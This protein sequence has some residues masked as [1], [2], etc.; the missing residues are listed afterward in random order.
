MAAIREERRVNYQNRL[1]SISANTQELDITPIQ[2]K[3]DDL[4]KE[5][6]ITT[7]DKG[8][9]DFS[10]SKL[11][12]A[13]HGKIENIVND[14]RDWGSKPG[15]TTP[16]MLDTLKQR[17]DDFYSPSRNSS[18]FVQRLKTTIK[19]TIVKD[20]P[21]Y[22]D[23]TKEYSRLSDDIKSLETALSLK[24][25]NSVN[26]AL[27][28]LSN[29]MKQDNQYRLQ[30]IGKLQEYAGRDVLSELAGLQFNPLFPRSG[31]Y[32]RVITGMGF[33]AGGAALGINPAFASLL[34]LGSPR[35]VGE[36]LNAMGIAQKGL[37]AVRKATPPL[38]G[39]VL[40]QAGRAKQQSPQS[41]LYGNK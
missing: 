34:A 41:V 39:N 5:Y 10:R 20:V 27:S 7:T 16:I 37:K 3:L 4:L 19:D 26:T 8:V 35:V 28:K 11:D 9:L 21:A 17:L 6:N 14:I 15:D 30:L 12:R 2:G 18:S 33:M 24:D 13:E 23:M 22:A 36:F 40:Y 1:Q 31:G 25:K 32:G 38:T 29:A